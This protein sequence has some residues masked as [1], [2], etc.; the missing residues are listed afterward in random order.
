MGAH[1]G[2]WRC[3][4]ER[5]GHWEGRPREDR[6]AYL[7]LAAIDWDVRLWLRGCRMESIYHLAVLPEISFGDMGR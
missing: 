5:A 7:V 1:R 3:V 4:Y 2:S 6:R